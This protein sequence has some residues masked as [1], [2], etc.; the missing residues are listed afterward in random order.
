MLVKISEGFTQAADFEGRHENFVNKHPLLNCLPRLWDTVFA[1]TADEEG[2]FQIDL[3]PVPLAE[4]D[5]VTILAPNHAA[6][7]IRLSPAK[8]H[9]EMR[10]CTGDPAS[11]R[12]ETYQLINGPRAVEDKMMTA[13]YNWMMENCPPERMAELSED[14]DE[15]ARYALENI[16]MRYEEDN[17]AFIQITEGNDFF[18]GDKLPALRAAV[19]SLTTPPE[20]GFPLLMLE[21]AAPQ[22]GV[23][24]RGP[25]DET[26]TFIPTAVDETGSWTVL[27]IQ[28]E[29][30][31]AQTYT[32]L[33][34]PG[35]EDQLTHE[36]LRWALKVTP[37]KRFAE[38]DALIGNAYAHIE[39]VRGQ[40]EREAE[41][42]K[43]GYAPPAPV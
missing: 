30:Q 20:D 7:T 28:I 43:A 34:T 38:V 12:H 40:E 13:F 10:I 23:R 42:L 4:K 2:I 18:S 25:R 5:G 14:M 33:D 11:G 32:A 21:R 9:V 8:D 15:A 16:Q 36:V 22:P 24:I 19:F 31:A 17:G 27:Q 39:Y 6:F 41:T 35:L 26:V 3:P 1:H 37:A 29:N